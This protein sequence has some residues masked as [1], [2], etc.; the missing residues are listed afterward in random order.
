MDVRL[1]KSEK[2]KG[3]TK[4]EVL[5]RLCRKYRRKSPNGNFYQWLTQALSERRCFGMYSEYADLVKSELNRLDTDPKM[6]RKKVVTPS[7]PPKDE[8]ESFPE[9]LVPLEDELASEDGGAALQLLKGPFW[10]SLSNA[11]RA[12]TLSA[13]L[14]RHDE[15]LPDP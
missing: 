1:R 9:E 6:K 10:A 14:A 15:L 11:D 4:V 13:A 2:E 7:S 5:A 8:T 12:G 3:V